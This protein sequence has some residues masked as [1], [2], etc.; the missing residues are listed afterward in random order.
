MIKKKNINI[1]HYILH[2]EMVILY[3]QKPTT[4]D[5]QTP[6]NGALLAFSLFQ[7]L[8]HFYRTLNNMKPSQGDRYS[9]NNLKVGDLNIHIHILWK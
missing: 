4:Y 8:T 6:L 3:H 2:K 7:D 9:D 5:T 1:E